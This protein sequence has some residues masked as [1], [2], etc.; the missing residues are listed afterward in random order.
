MKKT[1][2]LTEPYGLSAATLAKL[3]KGQT[4]DGSIIA[5]LC[6]GLGCQPGEIMAY[7]EDDGA[8]RPGA[9]EEI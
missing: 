9:G 4:V 2:L 1:D 3:S 5:R 6:K 8:E 7:V